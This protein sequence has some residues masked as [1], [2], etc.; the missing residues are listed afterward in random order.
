MRPSIVVLC[1]FFTPDS[2]ALTALEEAEIAAASE[3]A[4]SH[5]T[6]NATFMIFREGRFETISKGTNNFTCLVMRNPQGR[7]EPACL[8]EEAMSSVRMLLTAAQ[9]R[10][11]RVKAAV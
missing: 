9:R 11:A 2:W 5:I 6:G 1:S 10:G 4:P 3:A 8:N 7:F